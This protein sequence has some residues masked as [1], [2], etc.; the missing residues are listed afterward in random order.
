[1]SYKHNGLLTA[2]K[3]R[4]KHFRPWYKRYVWKRERQAARA[5]NRRVVQGRGHDE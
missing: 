5:L 1:M 4:C 2:A 3:E